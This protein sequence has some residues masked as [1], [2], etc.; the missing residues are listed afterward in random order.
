MQPVK[1]AQIFL[2]GAVLIYGAGG[3]AHALQA[4]TPAARHGCAVNEPDRDGDGVPDKDDPYPDDP[5][6]GGLSEKN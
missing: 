4:K 5:T 6:R 2:L 1:W 3:R